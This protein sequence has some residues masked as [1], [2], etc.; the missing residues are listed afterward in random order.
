MLWSAKLAAVACL[1][2]TLSSHC[3][4]WTASA[5]TAAPSADGAAQDIFQPCPFP[6]FDEAVQRF[7][8]VLSF[9]TLSDVSSEHHV[10]DPAP[11][12]ELDAFLPQAYSKVMHTTH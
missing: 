11:F 1:I 10:R 9:K 2:L 6:S 5:A 3:L 7:S 12:L 8:R 4:I